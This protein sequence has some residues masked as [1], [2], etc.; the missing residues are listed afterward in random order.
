MKQY[1]NNIS[2]LSQLFL[3]ILITLSS[4]LLLSIVATLIAAAFLGPTAITDTASLL[5]NVGFLKYFQIV[6]SIGL[7]IIPP[8]LF[9]YLTS[10]DL[11]LSVKKQSASFYIFI[12]ITPLT[13]L[14]AQPFISFLGV[15]NNGLVL[16]SSLTGLEE[17]MRDKEIQA[18]QATEMFLYS[19]HWGDTLLNVLVIAI[20]PAIGEELLFRGA[21]Q[22]V[23]TSLFRNKHISVIA[24][25]II[26][27]AIHIQFFGFLPRFLL[28]VIF[29][30]MMVYTNNIW[31][32]ILAHFTNNFMAFVLYQ[33][34]RNQPQD[35]INPL[36]ANQ[37]YPHAIWIYLSMAGTILL[38]WV[39][40]RMKYK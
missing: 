8:I 21:L 25:A 17:W 28:G 9:G 19:K 6:Q 38:L 13:V 27:S 29:G 3:L 36:E 18:M 11:L 35:T 23:F 24:T 33:I 10:G 30:Y 14:C 39:F 4:W 31:F 37:D 15:F 26:F 5:S 34:Y 22:R 40:K 32:P 2:P 16:P 20:L 1:F 7:F 12:T